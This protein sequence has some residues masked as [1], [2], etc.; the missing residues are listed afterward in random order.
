MIVGPTASGKTSLAMS[1]ASTLGTEIISSDAFQIYKEFNI[2]TAKPTYE[3]LLKIKHHFVNHI[4]VTQDYSVAKFSEEAKK[5][6]R[7]IVSYGKIPIISGGTG[8]YVDSLIHNFQ[9]A[10]PISPS[11]SHGGDNLFSI[12]NL[13]KTE[14]IDKNIFLFEELKKID[15]K[16]A[17][18][19]NPN[20]M[21]RIKRALDFFQNL[22]FSITSQ[23]ENTMKSEN[24]ET[25]RIGLNFKYRNL[26]YEKINNRVDKM[27]KNGLVR[28]IEY[29][30]KNFKVS[31]TASVA[32]GYKEIVSFLNNKITLEKAI[33]NIKTKT[34]HYAKRQITW[35]K[36]EHTKWFYIDEINDFKEII[37]YVLENLT[38]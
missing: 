5:I 30:N 26:L 36:R 31:R 15:P 10:K 17:E 9:F 34:R 19:I 37:N 3:Q 1:L 8:L 21:K 13:I 29:I 7:K 11:V 12:K 23:K 33:E 38:R 25:I 22:G 4:S 24:Y 32:I 28:E 20:D 27:L 16:S 14:I 2:C 6:I 18:N 35:F